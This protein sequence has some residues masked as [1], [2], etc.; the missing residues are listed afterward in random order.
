MEIEKIEFGVERNFFIFVL[1]YSIFFFL[2]TLFDRNIT[3]L[4]LM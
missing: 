1:N 2:E 4:F 3:K